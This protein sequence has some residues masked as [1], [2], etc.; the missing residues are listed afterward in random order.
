MGSLKSPCTT[1][2][3]SSMETIAQN[4]IAFAKI[5]FCCTHFGDRRTGEQMDSP[6]ALRR[7]RCR[8]R[9]LNKEILL[10]PTKFTQHLALVVQSH[11]HVFICKMAEKPHDTRSHYPANATLIGV[12]FLCMCFFLIFC[13][14]AVPPI[15]VKFWST[16]EL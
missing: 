7:S 3:R 6:D 10:W 2:C 1:S 16:I 5:A 12:S 8:E 13:P 11:I 4:S 15:V 14:G 9:R